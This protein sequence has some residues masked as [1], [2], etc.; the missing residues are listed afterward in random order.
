MLFNNQEKRTSLGKAGR[1]L[2]EVKYSWLQAG[3]QLLRD[4]DIA[5]FVELA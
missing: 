2:V 1:A 4:L 5:N 3:T